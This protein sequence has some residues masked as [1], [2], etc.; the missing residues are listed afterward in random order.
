M[1][2]HVDIRWLL[3]RQ[4]ELLGRELAVRDYSA[5]VA[6]VARH[7]VNTPSLDEDSPDAFWRAAA[8]LEQIVLLRPLPVR[9]ELFGYGVAIAYVEA[10]GESIDAAYEPWRE[11]ITDIR[12]LR[13]TVY[14]VADRLRSWRA[15]EA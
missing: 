4:E 9:N 13:L 2:L 14:D 7:R 6:A 5:L 1:D 10:S 15:P 12:A 8:L 3:D 11:L